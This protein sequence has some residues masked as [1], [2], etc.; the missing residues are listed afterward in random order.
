MAAPTRFY[1]PTI[2]RRRG[3]SISARWRRSSANRP[4]DDLTRDWSVMG[5]YR[6]VLRPK[7]ILSHVLVLVLVVVMI[8]L[9]FWQLRRLDEKK[10]YNASV[11]ANESLA[12]M[13]IESL[14]KTSDPTS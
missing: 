3:T 9:S 7:W 2:G 12:A 1:G 6:F 5:R 10:T 11:R 4:T 14:L 8:N 13:P